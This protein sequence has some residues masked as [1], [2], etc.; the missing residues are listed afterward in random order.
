MIKSYL[1][2]FFGNKLLNFFDFKYF[3]IIIILS[4]N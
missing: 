2:I 1:V 3:K 4:L